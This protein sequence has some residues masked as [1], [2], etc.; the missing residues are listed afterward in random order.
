[1]QMNDQIFDNSYSGAQTGLPLFRISNRYVNDLARA[2]PCVVRVVL[3][4]RE[5]PF[6]IRVIEP[7]SP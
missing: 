6:I 1:M 7:D 2:L 3:V 5:K 4:V